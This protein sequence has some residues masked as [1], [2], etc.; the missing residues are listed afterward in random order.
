M[1]ARRYIPF[2][3][4]TAFRVTGRDGS[5]ILDTDDWVEALSAGESG[6]FLRHVEGTH[7]THQWG[8]PEEG[9]LP[10]KSMRCTQCRAWDNGSYG[11]RAPCGYDFRG[12]ALVTVIADEMK[13]R[14]MPVSALT[15]VTCGNARHGLQVLHSQCLE[16]RSALGGERGSVPGLIADL[17]RMI[18][19]LMVMRDSIAAEERTWRSPRG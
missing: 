12:R 3:R 9:Q 7:P 11:S 15:R 6:N 8:A 1:T 10:D 5:I 16:A 2:R 14:Q 17:E 4:A 18:G 13:G 19:D